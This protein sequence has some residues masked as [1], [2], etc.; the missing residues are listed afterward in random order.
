VQR[1]VEGGE[2]PIASLRE[3]TDLVLRSELVAT[4]CR[5]ADRQDK[6]PVGAVRN[7]T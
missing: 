7:A 3:L 1:V 6:G 4:D 5:D 2:I